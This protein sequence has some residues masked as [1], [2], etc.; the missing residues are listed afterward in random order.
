MEDEYAI[1][2][3]LGTTF[4]C[5]GVYRNDWVE[6]I[7]NRIGEKI[8]PSVVIITNDSKIL[9]GEETNEYLVQNYDSCIYEVKRLI[10]KEIS[11]KERK[12]LQEKFPFQ[13]VT[14]HKGNFPE[15]KINNKGKEVTYSPVEISSYIIKKMVF[16]AEKYLKKAINQLV[17]TVPAYF[18]DSQRALTRQAAEALGLKVLRIINEP[19]AA[20]LAYGFDEK[21]KHNS[22]ILIFDLG[23]GTFDVS[24]LAL[25]KDQDKNETRFEVLGTSGDTNLGGEDFDNA[26]VELVLKKYNDQKTVEKIRKDKQAMKRLKVACENAKKLLSISD[27]AHIRIYEVIK[28]Q[29]NLNILDIIRRNEFEIECQPLFDRLFD[30]IQKAIKIA[31]GN[32]KAMNKGESNIVIDE[33]ILVGGSTRIPKVKELVKIWFPDCKINDSINPDEAIAYGATIEAEKILHPHGDK[34]KNFSLLDVTPFSLGTDVKNNSKDPEVQKEGL[35][36]DVIVKRGDHIPISS[37]RTYATSYDNQTS[38][39]ID[40]YE[41]EKKYIKYNHL[42]KKSNIENLTKRPQG[43]TKVEV[44]LDID[45]NG[46]LNVTA[47]ELSDDGKGQVVNLVIKNDEV[48]LTNEEMEKLKNK[49]KTLL[50]KIGE[51]EGGNN[52]DYINIKGILKKYYDAYEK[53]KKNKKEGNEDEEDDNDDN[54]GSTYL[55]NYYTTLEEFIDKFDKNFDNETVLFKFYL[56]IKDL[57]QKYLEALKEEV[58]RGEKKHIFEK[59]NK[60]IEIFIDKS[61]GYL[62]ELLE[63][64]SGLKK[65]KNKANFYK[66]IAFVII[67]LTEFGKTCV[68]S[69][70]PFCKYHSIIYFEQS[71]SYFE[72]YF[73]ISKKDDSEKKENPRITATTDEGTEDRENMGLLPQNDLANLLQAHKSCLTYLRDINSGAILLCEEF[74]K[75]NELIQAD[76]IWN[77]RGTG[78]TKQQNIQNLDQMNRDNQKIYLENYE[79]ILSE[80]QVS[81]DFTKKEALCIA[82]IIKINSFMSNNFNSNSRYLLSL[83]NRCLTIVDHLKLDKSEKWYIEFEQLYNQLKKCEP[84]DQNYQNDLA[85]MKSKYP[86]VFKKIDDNFNRKSAKDFIKFIIKEHP[87]KEYEKDKDKK[88]DNDSPET[89]RYLLKQYLPDNY[90]PMRSKPETIL[91]HC[92]VHEISKKLNYYY[93]NVY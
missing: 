12:Q 3:D 80:I 63:I 91:T 10:G 69:G 64:L 36:M 9:V 45:V 4:S 30:P 42:L 85:D 60:Y 37:K 76:L 35:L 44:I 7:P 70:E 86:D 59:I 58:E 81:K 11:E 67:K 39:S 62:N 8:T 71:N 46:I 89:L 38:M 87:Y 14:A 32:A 78:F 74:L 33:V 57:F 47:R 43:K 29:K 61:S 49:M 1:G 72:K 54:E 79:K 90:K 82:N 48:S 23:G 34:T 73:P 83:A 25:E 6:I 40:I 51:N 75:K 50:E 56:Y 66:I 24:I 2:L 19:T 28:G 52:M 55:I 5:I 84:K 93:S 65:V 88:F 26:L 13:I 68:F 18:S 15:I 21:Q 41:G 20:A 53:F 17:I 31:N 77:S 22:N 16:N 27:V 92:I